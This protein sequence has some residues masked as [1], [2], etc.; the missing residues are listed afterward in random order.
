MHL[1]F[2]TYYTIKL[3]KMDFYFRVI[4]IFNNFFI[5]EIIALTLG[6]NS[7]IFQPKY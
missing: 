7:Q 2:E 5:S 3:N 1:Y 4:N 6:E